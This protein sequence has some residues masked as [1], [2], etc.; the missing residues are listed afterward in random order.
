MG[1]PPVGSTSARSASNTVIAT[2]SGRPAQ[3]FRLKRDGVITDIWC[4]FAD[5]HFRSSNYGSRRCQCVQ[6]HSRNR[7]GAP[8]F[9]V[10]EQSN[11]GPAMRD[12]TPRMPASAIVFDLWT[13]ITAGEGHVLTELSSRA[14]WRAFRRDCQRTTGMPACSHTIPRSEGLRFVCRTACVAAYPVRQKPSDLH[15]G[16]SRPGQPL[17]ATSTP[18]SL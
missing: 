4:W 7:Q 17:P 8:D 14:C 16:E 15:L 9:P 2:G 3:L 11:P 6:K 5:F 1:C 13:S 18:T 12:Q 10:R